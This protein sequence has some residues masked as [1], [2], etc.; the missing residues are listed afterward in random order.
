MKCVAGLD[1]SLRSAG[2]GIIDENGKN[3][4][5][6]FGY[7][8]SNKSSERDRIER[9]VYI[10]NNVM[11]VLIEF[12]VRNVGIE[13]YGFSGH[14]LT[15]Q[16]DLGGSMKTQVYIGLKTV[17]ILIPAKSVR[18][19]L[20]NDATKDKKMVRDFLESC[21]YTGINNFDE[22]DA[23]AVAVIVN[24][25]T[26]RR[27]EISDLNKIELFNRIDFHQSKKKSE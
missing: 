20:I 25:W 27:S 23:L 10:V 21:G 24:D 16:A 1:L 12:N 5:F 6:S 19:Y 26:N 3:H 22:S 17:P 18:K 4:C 8:L 15:M 9:V 14:K 13:N 7:G 2:V 11:K